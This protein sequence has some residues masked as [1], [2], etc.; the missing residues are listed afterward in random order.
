MQL[1]EKHRPRTLAD[2]LCPGGG[3]QMNN[4]EVLRL[5]RVTQSKDWDRDAIW[6]EGPS[7]SG[8]TTLANILAASVADERDIHEISGADC[9]LECVQEIAYTASLSTWGTGWKVFIVNEANAMSSKAVQAWK[10]LLEPLK[11]RRL[12]IF[13]S[14]RAIDTLFE[15]GAENKQLASRCKVIRLVADVHHAALCL[16]RVAKAEG[17]DVPYSTCQSLAA[18]AEGNFRAALQ[19]LEQLDREPEVCVEADAPDDV[20]D[21]LAKAQA[22]LASLQPV[23]A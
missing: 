23:S 4:R 16:E 18:S 21:V 1:Y 10:T 13:T 12:F 5:Q 7:G 9:T 2:M 15:T 8:K 6:I 22:L 14:A 20:E 17:W 11:A 3:A 19:M